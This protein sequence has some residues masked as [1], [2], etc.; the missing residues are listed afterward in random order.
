VRSGVPRS[1][2]PDACGCGFNAKP[3]AA[4]GLEHKRF[5]RSE[6]AVRVGEPVTA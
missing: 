4:R 1:R 3:V 2:R 5:V 6:M